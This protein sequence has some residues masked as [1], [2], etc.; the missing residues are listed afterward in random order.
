MIYEPFTESWSR[1]HVVKFIT[2]FLNEIVN[3][4]RVMTEA[5]KTKHAIYFYND[6]INTE[7]R[8]LTLNNFSKIKTDNSLIDYIDYLE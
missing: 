1:H 2:L 8:A 5:D 3:S 4:E 6:Y 7:E